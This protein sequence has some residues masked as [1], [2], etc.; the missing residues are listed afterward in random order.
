MIVITWI[1]PFKKTPFFCCYLY[2]FD[3]YSDI[4]GP[5]TYNGLNSHAVNIFY[6]LNFS[7]PLHST[8]FAHKMTCELCSAHDERAAIIYRRGCLFAGGTIFSH[9]DGPMIYALD[10]VGLEFFLVQTK[11]TNFFFMV[12][13]GPQFGSVLF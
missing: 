8:C 12:S 13:S 6:V 10:G 9:E 5:I 11:A 7:L 1:K 4:P 3:N 2:V